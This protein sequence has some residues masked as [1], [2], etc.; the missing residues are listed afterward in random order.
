MKVKATEKKIQEIQRNLVSRPEPT[1]CH[2]VIVTVATAE[3]A[4]AKTTKTTTKL[5]FLS[6]PWD[7]V[8][9]PDSLGLI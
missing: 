1:L 3:K 9:S 7:Q 4:T 5:L 6:I 8:C 2:T